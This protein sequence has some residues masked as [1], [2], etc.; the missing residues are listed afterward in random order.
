MRGT[1][2]WFPAILVVVVGAC[3]ACWFADQRASQQQAALA[4]REKEL[5][6]LEEEYGRELVK[7][8]MMTSPRNLDKALLRHGLAMD[9]PRPDQIIRIKAD[10]RPRAGQLSVARIRAERARG[11]ALASA[12]RPGAR[13]AR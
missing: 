2:I 3:L 13:G 12:G 9:Q 5:K 10:G 11:G 7:W 1:S 6:S 4:E 8:E